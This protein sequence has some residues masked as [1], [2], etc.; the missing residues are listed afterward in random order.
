[1][2]IKIKLTKKQLLNLA[3]FVAIVGAAALFD[4]YLDKNPVQ[5][6]EIGTGSNEQH[7]E[8][9]TVYLHSQFNVPGA[10]VELQKPAFKKILPKIHDR[11][12]QKYHQARNY[13]VLKTEV[14]PKTSPLILGYHYLAFKNYYFTDP[15]DDH[16]LVS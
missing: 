15:D 6:D 10:K 13:Q 1:M 5:I 16:P 3:L 2:N 11:F 14:E 7:N 12:I 4:S 9:N 8:P